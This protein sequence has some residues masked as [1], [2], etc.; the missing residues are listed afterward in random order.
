[1]QVKRHTA[2][3][4]RAYPNRGQCA[5]IERTIGCARFV[6]NQ[7]LA[8]RIEHYKQTKESLRNTPAQYKDRFPFLKEVDSMALCNAQLYLNRAYSRFFK[9]PQHVG[10]PKFKAKHKDK[11]SYTTNCIKGNIRLE[12]DGRYLRLPKLGRVRVRQHKRIPDDWVL[13][14]VTVQHT[15][16][17]KYTMTILF[18]YE[19]QIPEPRAP[20]HFVGLDYSS[21][22]LYVSSDAEKPA[23]PRFYRRA[24]QCLAREQHKL[25]HMQEQSN[26]WYRQK[27]KIARLHERVRNTRR[28]FLHKTA[29]KLVEQY[30]CVCVEDLNL[31][32]V[33][34]LLK[35]GKSTM[36]NGFGL[37]RDMLAYKLE[38]HGGCMV[39]IDRFYPSSQLCHDCGYKNTDTKNLSVR[40]WDCPQCGVHHDRDVNAALNI[41]DEGK[42]LIS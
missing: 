10:F 39:K 30:D 5:L 41:R 36:D 40:E 9:D 3:V 25:S 33:S 4:Y 24:E 20:K 22:D 1:M 34:Q 23:Y 42:R 18:E 27:T 8:D 11:P 6:Y 16:S 13:K 15:R 26:N 37:L 32:A 14:S 7:M 38:K 35:L 29:N 12:D 19:T 31:Q 28:D 21:H 2:V 17:G